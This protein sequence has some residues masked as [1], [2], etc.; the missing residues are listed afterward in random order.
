[1]KGVENSTGCM[2]QR[3]A[4]VNLLNNIPIHEVAQNMFLFGGI[5][6]YISKTV[7]CFV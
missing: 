7:A 3:N 1:M 6:V 4:I 2:Q 5:I